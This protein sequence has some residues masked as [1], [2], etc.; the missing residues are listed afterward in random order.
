MVKLDVTKSEDIE[1]VVKR[2]KMAKTQLWAVVNNAGIGIGCPFDWGRDVDE[3]RKM[4]DV[5][6]FGLVR[7]TKACVPLL[8]KSNGR[9]INVSSLAGEFCLIL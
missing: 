2:I 1:N 6:V 4:F 9:I 3:Y 7:V 5:N 8:R